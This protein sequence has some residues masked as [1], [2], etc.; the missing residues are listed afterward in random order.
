[1]N[2]GELEK[3]RNSKGRID[4][5]SLYGYPS[6]VRGMF[7]I[8]DAKLFWK[9]TREDSY[10]DLTEVLVSV[11]ARQMELPTAR[12]ELAQCN[13]VDGVISYNVANKT[14]KI[15]TY[16]EFLFSHLPPAMQE[17][18]AKISIMELYE[19]LKSKISYNEITVQE[20]NELLREHVTLLIFDA[21]IINVDRHNSNLLILLDKNNKFRLS[22]AFD[23]EMSFLCHFH[24]Y[25]ISTCMR[26]GK[27]RS[28]IKHQV[29]KTNSILTID[30][31]NE[32]KENYLLNLNETKRLFPELF[33]SVIDK[34]FKLNIEKAF[35]TVEK[36]Q[37]VELQAEYKKWISLVFNERIKTMKKTFIKPNYAKSTPTNKDLEV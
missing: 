9:K 25:F 3:L 17:Y 31:K 7:S 18:K 22:P 14:D 19:T 20:A 11:L 33:K 28:I 23:H 24:S 6:S 1:M 30:S 10:S 29:H 4:I 34:I 8:D 32:N 2:S 13:G 5:S 21:A 36:E 35:E 26:S 37:K 16:N 15:I 12:Y 27:L